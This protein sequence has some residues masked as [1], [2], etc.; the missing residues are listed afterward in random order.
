MSKYVYIVSVQVTEEVKSEN[1][2]YET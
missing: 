1:T 2:Q